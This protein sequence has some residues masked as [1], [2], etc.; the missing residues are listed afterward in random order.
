MKYRNLFGKCACDC[1]LTVPCLSVLRAA[2]EVRRL[3]RGRA[4][5]SRA[6]RTIARDIVSG[7]LL[8]LP[9]Q[10]EDPHED[11][12]NEDQDRILLTDGIGR[13]ISCQ[14]RRGRE[15]SQHRTGHSRL[16]T[17]QLW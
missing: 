1:G 5:H 11:D 8:A 7:W 4:V 13:L 16:L 6:Q 10:E 17:P 12:R 2:A 9:V 3:V 14:G 15:S